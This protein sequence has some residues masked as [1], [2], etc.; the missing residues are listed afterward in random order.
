MKKLFYVWLVVGL[1]FFLSV[2]A[3][4]ADFVLCPQEIVET[5]VIRNETPEEA[6][7]ILGPF[8]PTEPVDVS[9]KLS[10]AI[11]SVVSDFGKTVVYAVETAVKMLAIMLLCGLASIGENE[12]LH[13]AVTAAG[14]ASVLLLCISDVKSMIGFGLSASEEIQNY[15][16]LLMPVMAAAAST[17]GNAAGAG[18]IHSLSVLFSNI[19]MRIGCSCVPPMIYAYLALGLTDA[20]LSQRRLSGLQNLIGWIIRWMLKGTMYLF[21]GF[22]TIFS[23]ISGHADAM[24]V[25]AAKVTISGM[26]PVVGSI[27]SDAAE[28]L[29]VGAGMIRSAVGTYGMLAMLIVFLTPFVRVSVHY[30]IFKITSALSVVFDCTFGGMLDGISAAMGYVLAVL[31]SS[32]LMSLLSCCC[33]MRVVSL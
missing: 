26:V 32:L 30:L 18:V 1:L 8:S 16:V 9:A 24:A 11:T 13:R 4:A 19:L 31:G 21:T 7:I 5:D 6:Q 2:P 10:A 3:H 23:V 17:A 14:A 15:S 29:L 22:L 12:N 25:K 20:A 33:F 27:I 28:T